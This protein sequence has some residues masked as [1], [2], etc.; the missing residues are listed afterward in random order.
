[1]NDSRRTFYTLS[2]SDEVVLTVSFRADIFFLDD[3]AVNVVKVI[4]VFNVKG[5][6]IMLQTYFQWSG[7]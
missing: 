5:K 7:Y 3:P 4:T 6:S 2:S 1:M